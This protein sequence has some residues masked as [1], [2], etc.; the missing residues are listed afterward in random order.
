MPGLFNESR[1]PNSAE[2]QVLYVRESEPSQGQAF[3][4]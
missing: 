1:L 4:R 3:G 2:G